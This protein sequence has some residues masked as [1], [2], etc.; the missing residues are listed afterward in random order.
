MHAYYGLLKV[1]HDVQ[2]TNA[3]KSNLSHSVHRNKYFRKLDSALILMM[4]KIIGQCSP[5]YSGLTQVSQQEET[6]E[7]MEL[8]RCK[9]WGTGRVCSM[10]E[11]WEGMVYNNWNLRKKHEKPM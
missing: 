10:A 6:G 2:Y 3:K 4:F 8:K 5:Q 9:S 7:E 11:I 1:R